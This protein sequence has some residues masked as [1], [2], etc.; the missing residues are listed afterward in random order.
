MV[1]ESG[2]PREGDYAT[3]W[4][5]GHVIDLGPGYA[6]GINDRGQV[7]GSS[8]VGSSGF[9]ATEWSRGHVID[10]G[11][12]PGYTDSL[13]YAINDA[14]QVVGFSEVGVRLTATEWSGGKVINLGGLP[15]STYSY[16]TSVN[17]A[18]EV[19]G[20]S[21]C[22]R[23]L[24]SADAPPRGLSLRPPIRRSAHSSNDRPVRPEGR[25]RAGGRRIG[26][27]A[28]RESVTPT[29]TSSFKSGLEFR[30]TVYFTTRTKISLFNIINNYPSYKIP[31]QPVNLDILTQSKLIRRKCQLIYGIVGLQ[32]ESIR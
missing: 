30:C 32:I 28:G 8:F 22:S 16:A 3:E 9:V 25:R 19:V 12:L 17:D 18:G 13:A 26:V 11:V 2:L 1:G 6:Y 14:G 10:L 5:G 27:C 23:S 21:P 4:S 24:V 29:A 20:H 15:G 7:V 31:I